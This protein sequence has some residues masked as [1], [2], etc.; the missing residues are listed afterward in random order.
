MKPNKSILVVDDEAGVREALRQILKPFYEVHIAANGEEALQCV[1]RQSI[2]LVTLDLKM[3]GMSGIEV[4]REI[5]KIKDDIEVIIITAY[6]NPDNAGEA[7][8]YGAGDFIAKPFNVSDVTTKVNQSLERRYH[9]LKVKNLI[10]H[11]KDLLPQGGN[12]KEERLLV[13]SK[14]LCETLEKGESSYPVGIEEVLNSN[15]PPLRP[16]IDQPASEKMTS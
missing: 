2:D 11:I 13:L 12:G 4:L 9:G 7:L 10:Q 14:N 8:Y 5:K 3:P 15:P 6:G 16:L 1:Q